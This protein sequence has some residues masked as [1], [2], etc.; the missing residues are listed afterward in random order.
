MSTFKCFASLV[1]AAIVVP[2]LSA[3]SQCPG[4]VASLP[5]RNANRDQIIVAVSVNHSGPYKF[6]LDTGSQVTIVD[7]SLAASLHLSAQG[8]AQVAGV[9]FHQPASI[10]QVELLEAGSHAVA[11]QKVMVYS[12]QNLH[13]A[14]LDIQGVLGE[15][16]L[17]HFDVL[18]DNEHRLLCLDDSATLREAVKG[19]HIAL[20]DSAH[21]E[22]AAQS[23]LLIVEARL[24]DGMRPV[25]LVLDSG[26][27]APFLSNAPQ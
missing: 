1:L 6:L 26:A 8:E 7:T 2:L 18:I 12:L 21:G 4:N 11:N 10:A 20:A 5:F 17:A 16:F 15:D 25:R 24:S 22:D 9:G 14:D 3:K 23:G 27:N 13:S 19:I